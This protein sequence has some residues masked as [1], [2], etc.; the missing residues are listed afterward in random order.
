MFDRRN[1]KGGKH[2][3]IIVSCSFAAAATK[4]IAH[5]WGWACWFSAAFSFVQK[6]VDDAPVVG[7]YVLK[8][9]Y[10]I[11]KKVFIYE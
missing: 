1:W 5:S 9:T 7:A 11:F 4:P 6:G 8:R 2:Q 3:G 10:K